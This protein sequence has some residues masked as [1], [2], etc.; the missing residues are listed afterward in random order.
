MSSGASESWAKPKC[1]E[2]HEI[3]RL[4]QI[5]F[6]F[7]LVAFRIVLVLVVVLVL[8]LASPLVH[9]QEHVCIFL[10]FFI[11]FLFVLFV[12]FDGT[13]LALVVHV[14]FQDA[15]HLLVSL[16]HF[17]DLFL[18]V[19]VALLIAGDVIRAGLSLALIGLFSAAPCDGLPRSAPKKLNGAIHITTHEGTADSLPVKAMIGR[20][21]PVPHDVVVLVRIHVVV[22]SGPVE[23]NAGQGFN[24]GSIWPD[25]ASI[26]E[27]EHQFR[28]KC[29]LAK[30]L[31]IVA[32]ADL[33]R[34]L[35]V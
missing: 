1:D 33:C 12:L 22:V 31:V 9:V 17:V 20:A 16:G 7:V 5:L 21:R 35:A 27:A 30:R 6:V 8:L 11:V 10:P 4:S 23:E 2:V 14:S 34:V 32:W 3:C 29:R 26:V 28:D 18:L 15:L 19:F 13:F 24:V 25:Q